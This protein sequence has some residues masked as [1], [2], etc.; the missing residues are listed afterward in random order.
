[1]LDEVQLLVAGGRPKVVAHHG[2]GFALGLALFV[3]DQHTGLLAEGRIRHYNI[4]PVARVSAQAIVSR[5]GRFGL[6]PRGS[7][8]M[9]QQVHRA[10]AHHAV[11]DVDAAHC[12]ELQVLLLTLVERRIVPHDVVVRG[13]QEPARAA[14]RVGDPHPR[15]RP[16]HL[17]DRSD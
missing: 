8:A 6:H 17:D 16:H 12:V 5:Y 11:H 10:E 2:Q 3:D 15:L 9:Q 14:R 7:D 13:E 1:M 4:E